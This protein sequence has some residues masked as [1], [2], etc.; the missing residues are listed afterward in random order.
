MKFNTGKASSMPGGIF[1]GAMTSTASTL[2]GCGILAKLLETEVLP[3]N[4]LGYG[5]MVI[6]LMAS[7]LGSILAWKRI[8]HQKAMVCILTGAAYFLILLAITALMFG[9]EYS[10]VGV[11]SLLILCGSTLA[12]LTGTRPISGKKTPKLRMKNW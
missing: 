9:G 5:V 10:G 8:K 6:L 11:T 12:M 4:T 7:Y 2:L 3:E 1:L